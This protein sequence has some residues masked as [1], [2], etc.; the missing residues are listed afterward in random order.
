MRFAFLAFVLLPVSAAAQFGVGIMIPAGRRAHRLGSVPDSMALY[1]P[2]E[3]DIQPRC[4]EGIERF[5]ERLARMPGCQADSTL[6]HCPARGTLVLRFTV[7]R[8][9]AIADPQVVKGGCSG[10]NRRI[11]CEALRSP[12]WEPG[13]IGYHKVASR[14]QVKLRLGS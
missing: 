1:A 6:R 7:E 2:R 4:T 12:P 5:T 10:L 14:L 13:R 11:E 8:D 3:L 9:G